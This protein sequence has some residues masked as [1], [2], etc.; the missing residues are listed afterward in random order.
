MDFDGTAQGG[1]AHEFDGCPRDETQF[2]EPH[3]GIL[4]GFDGMDDSPL[5]RRERREGTGGKGHGSS[6]VLGAGR[7]DPNAVGQPSA[8][9]ETHVANLT[10]D[11]TVLEEEPDL[12]FLA[13]AELAQALAEVGR[14]QQL[15]DAHTGTRL[16]LAEGAG[17][18]GRTATTGT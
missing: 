6:R 11:G 12:A 8:Q 15:L 4:K 7:F 5:P 3:A 17:S 2:K 1:E 16:D 14:S 13:E 10:D 18:A 9:A